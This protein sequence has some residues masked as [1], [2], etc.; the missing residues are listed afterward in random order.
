MKSNKVFVSEIINMWKT[1]DSPDFRYYGKFDREDTT[2]PFWV[3]G[4]S[5]R[6]LFTRLDIARTL[7]LACGIGRHSARIVDCTDQLYMLDTSVDAL[8]VVKQR[9]A[10][11]RNVTIL[12]STDGETIPALDGSLTAVFSYDAMVHFEAT[13]VASYLAE[14]ARVLSPGGGHCFTTLYMIETR[15]AI[16]VTILDG[17]TS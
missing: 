16:S 10:Q 17:A 7:E 4:G 12:L 5:F 2:E 15:L 13:T 3:E 6:T 8:E 9:F 11:Y 1:K 14:T